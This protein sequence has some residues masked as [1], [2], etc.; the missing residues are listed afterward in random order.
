MKAQEF[1][2]DG[3]K[4]TIKHF[5]EFCHKELKLTGKIPK[6]KFSH[7]N[8]DA[9][10]NHRMGYYDPDQDYIWVY[11]KNRNMAD[12]LRTLCHELVHIKQR[13]ENRIG[14]ERGPGV[15]VEREADETAGVLMK[16]YGEQNRRIYD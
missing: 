14:T 12:I 1:L 10:S 3:R 15:P 9:R 2:K 5:L 16:I 7:D 4:E 13:M 11:V 8:N 6:I